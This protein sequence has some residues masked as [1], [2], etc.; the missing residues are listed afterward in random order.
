MISLEKLIH[1]QKYNG[2]SD[3]GIIRV[4]FEENDMEEEGIELI[5]ELCILRSLADI[6][7]FQSVRFAPQN[8]LF[9]SAECKLT[10]SKIDKLKSEYRSV[11][12]W[13]SYLPSKYLYENYDL[14]IADNLHTLE[15]DFLSHGS[16]LSYQRLRWAKENIPN[17]ELPKIYFR[18]LI[19]LLDNKGI[20]FKGEKSLKDTIYLDNI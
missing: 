9:E 20:R 19:E 14:E 17:I 4:F 2:M 6:D 13:T 10:L 1:E 16:K 5:H 11:R 3:I 8:R 18:P 7:A 15:L 12:E